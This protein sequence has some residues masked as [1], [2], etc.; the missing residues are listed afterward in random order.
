[1]DLVDRPAECQLQVAADAGQGQQI[2]ESPKQLEEFA[3]RELD[4]DSRCVGHAM[5]GGIN[6]FATA[7][8]EAVSGDVARRNCKPG[9]HRSVVILSLPLPRVVMNL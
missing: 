2:R 5:N 7:P 4:T 1:M 6:P 3:R 9:V 8:R